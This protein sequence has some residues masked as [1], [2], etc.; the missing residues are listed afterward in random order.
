MIG[1]E[2]KKQDINRTY[3]LL[4]TITLNAIISASTLIKIL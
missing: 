4:T 3:Q 1:G 2:V